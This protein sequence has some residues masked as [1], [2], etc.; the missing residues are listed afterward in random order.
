MSPDN[1]YFRFFSASRA[2]AEWE[3]RRLCLEGGPGLV[4]LL[5]LLGDEVVGVA[6]YQLTAD[7]ALEL[8]LAIR[9][10]HAPARCRH[11]AG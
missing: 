6:S 8:A 1:L 3:A 2:S 11:V 9:R 7:A 5:G 4:A 10:Q